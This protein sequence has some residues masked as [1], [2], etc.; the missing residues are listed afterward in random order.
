[1]MA[2]LKLQTLVSEKISNC[3]IRSQT[4]SH[5]R[6][7][8][9]EPWFQWPSQLSSLA[10]SYTSWDQCIKTTQTFQTSRSEVSFSQWITSWSY[11]SS[12]LSGSRSTLSIHF[13]SCSL[14]LQLL[15]TPWTWDWLQ[16]TATFLS[17]KRKRK[18][19]LREK[20]PSHTDEFNYKS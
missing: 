19:A 11:W 14:L 5:Q 16:A 18:R 15:F 9:R 13:G 12:L 17:L 4:T 2:Q 7:S 20:R 1:M 3:L 10:C 6:R 8:K